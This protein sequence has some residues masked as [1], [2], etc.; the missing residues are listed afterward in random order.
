[1]KNSQY[2]LSSFVSKFF[3]WNLYCH[4]MEQLFYM[5]IETLDFKTTLICDIN[6]IIILLHVVIL[7]HNKHVLMTVTFY[8]TFDFM[9]Q[10]VLWVAWKKLM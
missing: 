5:I 4:Q 3:E 10:V 8:N 1:M 7:F 6:N 2:L 9:F